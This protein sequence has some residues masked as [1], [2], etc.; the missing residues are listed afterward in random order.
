MNPLLARLERSPIS[1]PPLRDFF[2]ETI[3]RPA[4]S[5]PPLCPLLH[6]SQFLRHHPC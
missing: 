3:P 4:G 1:T 2:Q 6:F 5:E